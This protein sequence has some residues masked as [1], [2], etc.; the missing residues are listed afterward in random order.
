[1]TAKFGCRKQ[2]A[3]CGA[4]HISINYI[5]NTGNINVKKLAVYNAF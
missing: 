2:G 5:L 1:M 3:W 4:E